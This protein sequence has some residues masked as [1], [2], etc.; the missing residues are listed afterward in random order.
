MQEAKRNECRHRRRRVFRCSGTYRLEAL[1][2]PKPMKRLP[3]LESGTCRTESVAHFV[4]GLAAIAL[5][6]IA[7]VNGFEFAVE[8][9]SIVANLSASEAFID[10]TDLKSVEPE[11]SKRQD[12]LPFGPSGHTVPRT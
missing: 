3:G 1:S 4:L 6:A 5:I 10:N 9:D 12:R 7:T 8:L 11:N 2:R